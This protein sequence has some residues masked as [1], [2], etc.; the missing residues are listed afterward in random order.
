MTAA[1]RSRTRPNAASRAGVPRSGRGV[2]TMEQAWSPSSFHRPFLFDQYEI[3]AT[4]L[5]VYSGVA[6]RRLGSPAC[7]AELDGVRL[8]SEM[9]DPATAGSGFLMLMPGSVSGTSSS[10]SSSA[11]ESDSEPEPSGVESSDETSEG[12]Y[13]CFRGDDMRRFTRAVLDSST[14]G[15]MVGL[16]FG[17]PRVRCTGGGGAPSSRKLQSSGA[18]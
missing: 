15:V 5:R 1:G 13:S 14:G 3:T 6:A 9:T 12:W 2:M 11:D 4:N 17:G 10:S 16:C 8:H 18:S 7:D